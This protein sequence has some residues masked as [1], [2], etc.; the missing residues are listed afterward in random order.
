MKQLGKYEVLEELG[1]GSM[2][3]VYRARDT[4]LDRE[5]ALKTIG[6]PGR[7]DPEL[8]ERFYR[9]ARACARMQHPNVVMI[10]ELGEQDG[11]LF[12]A[13]ELLKGC[14]LHHFIN[15]RRPLSSSKKVAL[16]VGVCEGLHHA[17]NARIVHRDIKP[18]NVFLTTENVAKILDFGVARLPAS[19]L[20]MV[21][22]V[23]GTPSYMAPEQI[24]GKQVDARCDI[25]ALAIVIF[26]FL[27]FVHPFAGESVPK[28]I[29]NDEPDLLRMRNPN[30]PADLE[31]VIAKGLAKD[32]DQRYQTADEFAQAL[33]RILE[34]SPELASSADEIVPSAPPAASPEAPIYLNTEYKMSEI[35]A[36]LQQFDAAMEQE[37][38]AAARSALQTV[39]KLAKIDDRFAAAAKE[40]R[41]RLSELEAR[42]PASPPASAE[43]PQFRPPEA[44]PASPGT[45]DET[46]ESEAAVPKPVADPWRSV[47]PVFSP[48]P[49][50]PQPSS[51]PPPI[52]WSEPGSHGAGDVTSLFRAGVPAPATP[53]KAGSL[54]SEPS[55]PDSSHRTPALG[56]ARPDAPRLE[57]AAQWP[58]LPRTQEQRTKVRSPAALFRNPIVIMTASAAVVVAV[59][60]TGYF[61]LSNRSVTREPSLATA[62]VA[63]S[64]ASLFSSPSDASDVLVSLKKGQR[65]NV[66]FPP[67]SKN[68]DWTAVQYI[69]GSRVYPAGAMRTSELTN[70]SSQRPDI[71][72]SLLEMYAP[73]ELADETELRD[74]TEKLS[75]FMQRFPGTAQ[76]AQAQADLNKTNAALARFAVA[77]APPEPAAPKGNSRPGNRRR[78][79]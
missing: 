18:S 36:A 75:V 20:T 44:P 54:S 34:Q 2:G 58:I 67:R 35:L 27:T 59:T 5:V 16:M 74:Y 8:K 46:G 15:E 53:P 25:F 55:T 50:K 40:S 17:H 10:Y 29:I 42:M 70:W 71:A 68:Q 79:R 1:T 3:V 72:L 77:P 63:T 24:M 31:A 7:L 19:M 21:G 65:L 28:R 60:L 6:G 62:E 45:K 66:L 33:R 39:E 13:L 22:R 4:I 23:V 37:N 47:T 9:E 69:A 41:G 48:S 43:P 76:V 11:M 30:L 32:P 14:D 57:R 56:T 64:Q 49:V 38:V 51:S 26:E 61:W 73:D 52:S 78:S 12:I